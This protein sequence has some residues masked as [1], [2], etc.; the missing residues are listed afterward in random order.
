M[1]QLL[2][3]L[4][5]AV[6]GVPDREA[7]GFSRGDT[8][9]WNHLKT[10][11]RSA[12]GGYH[13]VLD[14]HRLDKLVPR[15]DETPLE[16]RGYAYE[17]AAMGLTGMDLF[18]PG[19]RLQRYIDGPGRPHIYMVHIGAGEALARLKRKPEPFLAKLPDPALRWLAMDGYGFHEGFFKPA[20]FVQAKRVPSHLSPFGRRVFDQGVGRSI[21]F[22]SGAD[23]GEITRTIAAFP[24]HRHA[25][26]WLGVGVACGYVGGVDR[27]TVEQ[28]RDAAGRH[29]ARV[30]VGTAFV[31]KG[32]I[33]AGNPIPGTELA[34]EV[35]CGMTSRKAAE[36]VDEAF[37]NLPDSAAR[38]AYGVLQDRLEAVFSPAEQSLGEPA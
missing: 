13:A 10:V 1:S 12:V 15:L 5:R 11:V 34:C 32:R 37:R 9:N 29:L 28:L 38:P 17:G 7:T 20:R 23:V 18:L 35:L 19:S 21:W 31:A 22:A 27:A 24:A 14:G 4:R 30:A 8:P 6:M 36:H 33:R 26:L 16:L 25:D 3:R 2:S